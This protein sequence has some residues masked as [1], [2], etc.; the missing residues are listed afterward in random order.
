MSAPEAQSLSNPTPGGTCVGPQSSDAGIAPGCRGCPNASICAS[1]AARA[2]PGSNPDAIAIKDRM[3]TVRHKVLILSGKGGVGKSTLTK[4]LGFSFSRA[5]MSCGLVDTDICGPSLPRL[6]GTRDEDVHQTAEGWQPIY[7]DENLCLISMHFLLGD[8]NE[9]V[10]WRGPKKNAMITNFLKDVV[11]GGLE[12]LLFDTPPGTSDEHISTVK[13]L[14]ECAASPPAA[15]AGTPVEEKEASMAADVLTGAVLITTPQE[16]SVMDV[17][18]EAN[19]CKKMNIPILGFVENMSG[20]VCPKCDGTSTIFP[21]PY[22]QGSAEKLSQ[23]F[24]AP[25]LGKIP[26]DPKLMA[27]C[28]E[29][30]SL[31]QLYQEDVAEAQA[32]AESKGED[33]EAAGAKVK[34]SP[35]VSAIQEVAMKLMTILSQR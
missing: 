11:W 30:I 22:P 2:P 19:F 27:A 23:E 6:T 16:V 28:E 9:A 8:R 21:S 31:Y 26:L 10:V 24:G 20:F 15:A 3:S 29:G 5:G 7:V 12:V 13:L 17:R 25:V 34:M 1:G 14:Q 18:R 35:A 4:E 33:A 32:A